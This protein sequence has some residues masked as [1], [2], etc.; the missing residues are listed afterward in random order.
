MYVCMFVRGILKEVFPLNAS[1]NPKGEPWSELL[2]R[3][4][5]EIVFFLT[6][7]EF[8]NKYQGKMMKF[9]LAIFKKKSFIS[10]NRIFILISFA[11]SN[12]VQYESYNTMQP[13]LL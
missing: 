8:F 9:F 2:P 3:I 4:F 6:D 11:P 12:A 1:M 5:S 13:Q 10:K 7:F